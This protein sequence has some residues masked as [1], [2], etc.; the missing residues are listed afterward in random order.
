MPAWKRLRALYRGKAR[1]TW[2]RGV[3]GK[4]PFQIGL[5]LQ[6]LPYAQAQ[7]GIGKYGAGGLAHRAGLNTQAPAF[8]RSVLPQR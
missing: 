4:P 3:S 7:C 1:P 2:Q 8:N 6:Q 5:G